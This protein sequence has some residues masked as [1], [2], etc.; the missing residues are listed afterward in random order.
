MRKKRNA[1]IWVTYQ[2]S[3]SNAEIFVNCE[4]VLEILVVSDI[5]IL[6][7]FGRCHTIFPFELFAQIG[8]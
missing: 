5:H 1:L 4:S 2:M 7:V 3:A 6:T 8:G